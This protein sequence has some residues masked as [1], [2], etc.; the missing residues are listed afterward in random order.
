MSFR[1]IALDEI[2]AL[3]GPGT[4]TW[5]PVRATLG[6]R[7]FGANAYTA[8]AAGEDVVEPHTEDPELAHEELYFV[9]RGRARFTLDGEQVDAP[10]GTYVFVDDPAVHRHAVALEPDT[11][12]L[13]FGGPPTFTP[14]A[15]EW[16]FRAAAVQEQDPARAREILEDGFR[17]HPDSPSLQFALACV[18]ALQGRADEALAMLRAAVEREPRLRDAA[19]TDA[20]FET[21]RDDP[22]FRELTAG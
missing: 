16:S 21:L 8:G 1:V 19:R 15:W 9:A 2:E 20:D 18:E 14:S 22:R 12:V 10:A 7:A 13:S 3:P 11:T 4:L 6:I 5:R 17:H